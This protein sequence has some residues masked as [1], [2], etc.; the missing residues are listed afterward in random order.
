MTWL[1][2]LYLVLALQFVYGGEGG[3]PGGGTPIISY[4]LRLGSIFWGSKF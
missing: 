4:I 1:G 2:W 3:I